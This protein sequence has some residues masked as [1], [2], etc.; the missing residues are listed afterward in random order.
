LSGDMSIAGNAEF[1]QGIV[2]NDNFGGNISFETEALHSSTWNESHVDGQVIKNGNTDF[3]YPIGDKKHYRYA[4]I[5]APTEIASTFTGKYFF[6]NS[7]TLYPHTNKQQEI[8][9]INNQEY[10]TLTKE[11]GTSDILLTLSWDEMI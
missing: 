4:R 3:I 7:N 2:D 6:E 1:N 5:S 8:E 9:L 11:N 10:W